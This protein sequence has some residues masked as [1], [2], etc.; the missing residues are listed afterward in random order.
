MIGVLGKW[1]GRRLH[2]HT[3]K[4]LTHFNRM[5]SVFQNLFFS[6]KKKSQNPVTSWLRTCDIRTHKPWR[7]ERQENNW[8]EL[9][10]CSVQWRVL[11]A[12]L[13]ENGYSFKGIFILMWSRDSSVSIGTKLL[14]ECQGFDPLF[15][16]ASRPALRPT[17][18]PIQW[19]PRCLSLGIKRP[20]RE[21]DH[22]PPFSAEVKNTW[23]YAPTSKYVVT[24]WRLF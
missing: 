9:A 8:I 13:S 12:V 17:Q 4:W 11:L 21:S 19:G 15:S 2:K 14:A 20:E 24:M 5:V 7:T 3:E 18:P 10:Q 23:S 16:T 22:S 1:D 6:I